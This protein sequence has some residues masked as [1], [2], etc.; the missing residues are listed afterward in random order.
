[1]E[2]S[3]KARSELKIADNKIIIQ[4]QKA[5]FIVRTIFILL[6]ILLLLMPVFA[7]IYTVI[8]GNTLIL[9]LIISA[10]ILGIIGI[11]LFKKFLWINNGKE[12]ITFSK[13]KI[14]YFVD[15]KFFKAG[16]QKI[17]T[18]GL[19]TEIIYD[20]NKNAGQ[21]RLRNQHNQIETVLPVTVD[22]LEIIKEVITTHY[23][24]SAV[25]SNQKLQLEEA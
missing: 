8:S 17:N 5:S 25:T 16:Q 22:E 20:E 10:I 21:L 18:N 13:K 3:S 19:E 9:S 1:M 2:Y 14:K 24:K 4:R 15:Y 7:A 11:Y 6:S 23:A 12:V